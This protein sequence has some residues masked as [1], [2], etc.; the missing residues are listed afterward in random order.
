MIAN[1]RVDISLYFP[2]NELLAGSPPA[3]HAQP[4]MVETAARLFHSGKLCGLHQD[5]RL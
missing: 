1:A 4:P 2:L 3:N 5:D